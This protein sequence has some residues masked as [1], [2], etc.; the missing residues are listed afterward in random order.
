MSEY[1]EGLQALER[2]MNR[3]LANLNKA[4]SRGMSDVVFD[5]TGRA[6]RLAP[7]DLGDLRGSANALVNGQVIATG[8]ANGGASMT[9]TAPEKPGKTTGE[10]RFEEPYAVKQHEELSY[11]H[12]KGGQ[13]KYLEQPLA[14]NMDKYERHLADSA[15]DAVQ[16]RG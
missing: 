8:D 2:E 5:L 3:R 15:S 13:A 1:L 7:I 14:E 12:P 11:V 4:S 9:G 16:G 6:A 10:V